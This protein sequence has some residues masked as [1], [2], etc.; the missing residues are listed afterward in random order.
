MPVIPSQYHPKSIFRNGVFSTLF[1]AKIRSVKGVKQHRERLELSDGDFMDLEWTYSE[2]PSETCIIIFHGLEGNAHRSY[3]L[4]SVKLFTENGFDCCAPHYR[5]CSG[6]PN[7]VLSSYHSGRTE[8]LKEVIVHVLSKGKYKNIILKGFSLGGNL[9]LKY[10]GENRIR[11]H[12]LKGVI[13]VSAPVDLEGCMHQLASRRNTI[14]NINFLIDLKKKLRDK[15]KIFSEITAEDINKIKTLKDFDD[16]YTSRSNGF[17]DAIDYYTKSSSKQFLKNIQI[18]TL[19]INAKNDSFLSDSCY[20]VDEAE[21]NPN[22]FLETPKYGGHVG[23]VDDG[24]V[25]YNEKRAL[26]FI[27]EIFSKKYEIINN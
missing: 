18:P 16:F 19:I 10:A 24:N 3:V 22:L 26:E 12:E 2:K 21:Q 1:S 7:R 8:D 11:P 20:P 14:Y 13:A 25:Y 6:E 23:F 17:A 5:N 9:S 27:Q 15:S 4:G